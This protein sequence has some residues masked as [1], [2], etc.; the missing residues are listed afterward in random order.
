M[1]ETV[2]RLTRRALAWQFWMISPPGTVPLG[3]MGPNMI[4]AD[5]PDQVPRVDLWLGLGD[6]KLGQPIDSALPLRIEL[7]SLMSSLGVSPS[8]PTA[9]MLDRTLDA[10]R[11]QMLS[12]CAVVPGTRDTDGPVHIDPGWAPT[13]LVT[14]SGKAVRPG[15]GVVLRSDHRDLAEFPPPLDAPIQALV[16][17]SGILALHLTVSDGTTVDLVPHK[18]VGG[19]VDIVLTAGSKGGSES[20]R[21]SL[22]AA[23][24]V[25]NVG[26]IVLIN[27]PAGLDIPDGVEVAANLAAALRG[28]AGW[29]M[30]VPAG[31][32]LFPQSAFI[33]RQRL[34]L[35][36]R[37]GAWA[38]PSSIR[39]PSGHLVSWREPART[40]R[41]ELARAWRGGLI[42]V[43]SPAQ[44]RLMVAQDQMKIDTD[45]LAIEPASLGAIDLEA[46][47]VNVRSHPDRAPQWLRLDVH[48]DG[49]VVGKL[50][51]RGDGL[52]DG[53]RLIVTG[54]VGGA[55][56][57]P[58]NVVA[59]ARVAG[60]RSVE[61]DRFTIPARGNFAWPI[62]LPAGELAARELV[63]L[64]ADS[65]VTAQDSA[66]PRP[67]IFW[68][69]SVTYVPPAPEPITPRA[70]RRAR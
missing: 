18:R 25:H 44:R 11:R 8:A 10:L 13:L 34:R 22:R 36:R 19:M 56:A 35:D 70:S 43:L 7:V 58:C 24:A 5:S 61:V 41:P 66:D 23:T 28:G 51:L 37:T 60:G 27:P 69:E 50:T 30:V 15:G 17:V 20:W 68:L 67:V 62:T 6:T 49:A 14:V 32:G 12:T 16:P 48:R 47:K 9:R 64:P 38:F 42:A 29:A 21:R 33:V 59:R 57:G 52:E 54:D 65:W 46:W 53:G 4:L 1:I 40:G 3:A 55:L 39:H 63:I 2:L 26:R 31:V 45:R